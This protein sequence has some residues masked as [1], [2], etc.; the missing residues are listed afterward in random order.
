MG[1]LSVDV[2]ASLRFFAFYLANG[3]IDIDLLDGIDYRPVFG[4]GSALEQVFAIYSNVLEVDASGQV[5]NDGDAQYRAA[6][7]I[8]AYCDPSYQIEPP[9]Q[10][11]ETELHGPYRAPRSSGVCGDNSPAP[12]HGKLSTPGQAKVSQSDLV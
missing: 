2:R 9:L 8:R 6:Q 7:W 5:L 4:T 12:A 3:T 1:H 10:T 11:W